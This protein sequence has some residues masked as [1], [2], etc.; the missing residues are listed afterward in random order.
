M[1]GFDNLRAVKN[2]YQQDHWE[3]GWK[4]SHCMNPADFMK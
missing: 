2:L 1:R 3:S 4:T